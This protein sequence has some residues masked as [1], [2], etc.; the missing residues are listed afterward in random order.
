MFGK[1]LL[2]FVLY[3]RNNS[4]LKYSFFRKCE[5]WTILTLFQG[6]LD[7]LNFIS[8][9]NTQFKLDFGDHWTI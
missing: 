2:F 5:Q 8:G 1:N 4:I 7:N 6:P 3:H 9:T